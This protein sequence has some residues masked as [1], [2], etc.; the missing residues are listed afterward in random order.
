MKH[1]DGED[2]EYGSF[3]QGDVHVR[4]NLLHQILHQEQ[5]A[6]L[7]LELEHVVEV[8]LLFINFWH[9]DCVRGGVGGVG[10]DLADVV[11]RVFRP[12]ESNHLKN[13]LIVYFHTSTSQIVS[14][15]YEHSNND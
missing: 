14:R 5:Q 7:L 4:Q 10:R 2:H 1:L 6:P 3:E 12:L 9:R 8:L 11:R 13:R 15:T